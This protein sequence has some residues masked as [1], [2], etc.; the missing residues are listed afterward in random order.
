[1][2][3]VLLLRCWGLLRYLEAFGRVITTACCESNPLVSHPF[4]TFISY[5]SHTCL[6]A[7]ISL[8]D[9]ACTITLD[10]MG[11]CNEQGGD[12]ES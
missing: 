9:L 6:V 7:I 8:L 3:D 11:G 10:G 1:V 12:E 4:K 5:F 2:I